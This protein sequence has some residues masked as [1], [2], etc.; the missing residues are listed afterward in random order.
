MI[1]AIKRLG[2]VLLVAILF[3]PWLIGLVI[4]FALLFIILL[5]SGFCWAFTGKS[6][7]DIIVDLGEWY[8]YFI[9][10]LFIKISDKI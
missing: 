6:Y 9:P 1:K 7:L 5:I 3:S 4:V 8:F 2:L 10:N